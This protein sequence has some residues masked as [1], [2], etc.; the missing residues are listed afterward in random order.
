MVDRHSRYGPPML[1]YFALGMQAYAAQY[2]GRHE[3]ARRL[4]DEGP[5]AWP[6][7]PGPTA[8]SRPPRPG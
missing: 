6:C 8:C 4:F 2:R 1:H 7:P 3:E 5:S